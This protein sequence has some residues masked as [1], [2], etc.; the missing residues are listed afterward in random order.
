MSNLGARIDRKIDKVAQVGADMVILDLE[1]AVAVSQ[2]EAARQ[3]VVAALANIDFG[4]T[5]RLVRLNSPA[6]RGL[7]IWR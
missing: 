7:D 4:Q 2:K 3:N 6:I 1:D 5:E